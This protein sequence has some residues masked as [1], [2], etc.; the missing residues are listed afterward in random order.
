MIESQ[1][2]RAT[3]VKQI[4]AR[5]GRLIRRSND[6]VRHFGKCAATV[7]LLVTAVA[8]IHAATCASALAAE[9]QRPNILWIIVDDMSPN[10]SCYGETAIETPH[11]DRLARE[12]TR[13][14]NA[15]ITAPVCSPCRS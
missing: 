11:V 3:L 10:F 8:S 5:P 12:G 14:A 15:F 2:E 4:P 7:M 13:F 1:G 6:N 9:T